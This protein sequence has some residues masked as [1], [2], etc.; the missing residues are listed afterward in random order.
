[1]VELAGVETGDLLGAIRAIGVKSRLLD[2]GRENPQPPSSLGRE[3][4]VAR[5][6]ALLAPSQTASPRL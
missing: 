6:T 3:K 2:L 4:D 1:M 5:K